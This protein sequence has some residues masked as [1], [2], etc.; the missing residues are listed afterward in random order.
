M[1]KTI[2]KK[3]L[4]FS[5]LIVGLVTQA[6][7]GRMNGNPNGLDRSIGGGQRFNN[8][9]KKS[10]PVDY[11]KL[12]VDNLTEKLNLDGFQSAILKNILE[13][14]QKTT[15]AIAE[16]NIPNQG[17]LEKIKSEKLKMD[18]HIKEILNDDQ[19]KLFSELKDTKLDK[20]KKKNRKKD[21]DSE[22]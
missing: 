15:T 9:P 2:F 16:E 18:E 19:K 13:E 6:Q 14:Y 11:V 21:S 7:S 3:I 22:E 20:K 4:I 1:Q 12:T 17:K 10:E 8:T 5:V